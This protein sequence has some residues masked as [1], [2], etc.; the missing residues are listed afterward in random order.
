VD[1]PFLLWT[2]YLHAFGDSSLRTPEDTAKEIGL[3]IIEDLQ[4]PHFQRILKE[5]GH[6]FAAN[7]Y[8]NSAGSPQQ[9]PN[10]TPTVLPVHNDSSAGLPSAQ[11]PA[12]LLNKFDGDGFP[13]A[14]DH[15]LAS[16]QTIDLGFELTPDSN[17]GA[18][19]LDPSFPDPIDSMSSVTQSMDESS[20]DTSHSSTESGRKL[21]S[22]SLVRKNSPNREKKFKPSFAISDKPQ[23]SK[24]G[25]RTRKFTRSTK[26][27][28]EEQFQ[29]DV[30]PV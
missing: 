1:I 8:L 3:D 12:A 17:L 25:K 23:T 14:D 20:M 9:T 2:I 21:R 18:V 24:I 13:F 4:L 6:H 16:S 28:D 10:S 30:L 22:K 11:L 7:T 27:V 26:G 29:V 15:P 5:Q 19:K